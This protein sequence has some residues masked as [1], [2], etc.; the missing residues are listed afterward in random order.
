MS[1]SNLTDIPL[2]IVCSRLVSLK[3]IRLVFFLAELNGIESWGTG[4]GK[5]YLESKTKEKVY[6]IAGLEFGSLKDHVLEITK[7]LHGMR[8]SDLR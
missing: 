4:I 5:T 2:S 7:T 6:I 8:A 3:G 1:D